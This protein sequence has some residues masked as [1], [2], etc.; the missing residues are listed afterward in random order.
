MFFT[1]NEKKCLC[2]CFFFLRFFRQVILVCQLSVIII[3]VFININLNNKKKENP[4]GTN[5]SFLR[6]RA[7]FLGKFF[8]AHPVHG[9]NLIRNRF[10]SIVVLIDL[11]AFW[12]AKM[13]PQIKSPTSRSFLVC[14]RPYPIKV[15]FYRPMMRIVDEHLPPPML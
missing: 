10:F 12:H 2:E 3:N 6:L 11:N 14:K 7:V 13:S 5:L 1:R 8:F 15:T 9:D 4:L